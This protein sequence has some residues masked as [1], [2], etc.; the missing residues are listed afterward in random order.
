MQQ[1]GRNGDI[2]VLRD[3]QPLVA[4]LLHTETT[5]PATVN[6]RG[7][8]IGGRGGGGGEGEFTH[9]GTGGKMRRDS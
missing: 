5:I 2:A 4:V 7:D 8:E 3:G 6:E 1:N 9:I